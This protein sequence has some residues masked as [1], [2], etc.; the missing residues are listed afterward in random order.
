M[1]LSILEALKICAARFTNRGKLQSNNELLYIQTI[2]ETGT[3]D[4]RE[5]NE[6]ILLLQQQEKEM[7]KE[8]GILDEVLQI[9]GT[10]P[11]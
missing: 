6:R 8:L 7:V 2:N 3:V 10:A 5:E 1:H 11:P 4:I 9:H